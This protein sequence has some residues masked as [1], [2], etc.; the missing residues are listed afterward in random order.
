MSRIFTWFTITQKEQFVLDKFFEFIMT[1]V[2]FFP[3][4][5]MRRVLVK[6][7]FRVE[8]C[9][10]ISTG[11][12][13]ISISHDGWGHGTGF[14]DTPNIIKFGKNYYPRFSTNNEELRRILVRYANVSPIIAMPD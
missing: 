11:H 13:V 5:R 6:A 10:P 1:K 4:T 7:G 2:W 8:Y 14:Y 3:R 9:P 12:P